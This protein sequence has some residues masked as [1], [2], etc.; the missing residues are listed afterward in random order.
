M[1]A[2]TSDLIVK[3]KSLL[4]PEDSQ[5]LEKYIQDGGAPLAVG[6][7]LSFFELFLNGSNL[8]EVHRLNKAFP[9]EAVLWAYVKYDWENK[10]DTAIQNQMTE[11]QQ[12]VVKATLDTTSLVTNLLAAAQK[13]HGDKLKKYLQTGNEADLGD[14]LNV[15]SIN[16]LLK[17]AEALQ[18]ITGQSNTMN[19]N[20]KSTFEV[21]VGGQV[22]VSQESGSVGN[23]SPEAAAQVL[24][25]IAADMRKKR[26]NK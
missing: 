19:I 8:E 21:K 14:A 26:D 10:R 22:G 9:Y 5:K 13:K 16:E 7:A 3:S 23:L 18:K 1:T 17:T 12:K 25:A 15:R 6:T 20:N 2:G 11:I 24:A 4:L